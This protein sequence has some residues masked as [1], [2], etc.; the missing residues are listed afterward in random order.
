VKYLK[1]SKNPEI[2]KIPFQD[3]AGLFVKITKIPEITE[4]PSQFD[5]P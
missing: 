4:I 3:V 2:T 5:L 1:V